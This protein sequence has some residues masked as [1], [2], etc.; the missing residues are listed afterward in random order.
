MN[1]QSQSTKPNYYAFYLPFIQMNNLFSA[2]LFFM[3]LELTQ[4]I[5]FVLRVNENGKL[6]NVIQLMN[7]A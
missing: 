7:L 6:L 2:L 1:D 4:S 3:L 5:F